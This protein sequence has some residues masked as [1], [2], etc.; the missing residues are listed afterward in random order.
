MNKLLKPIFAAPSIDLALVVLRITLGLGLFLKH[1][2][3]KLTGFSQMATHFPD[4]I[5][6][7]PIPSLAFALLSDG[8]CSLLI[9]LG[10]GTR[11]AAMIVTINLLVVFSILHRF[12]LYEAHGELVWIYLGGFLTLVF[13]GGGRFSLDAKLQQQAQ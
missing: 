7:G 11:L 12:N 9:I 4:P 6:I 1:G 5:G 8:I 10:I 3:E 2:V 13:T